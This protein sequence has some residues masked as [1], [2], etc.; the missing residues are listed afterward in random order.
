MGYAGGKKNY[1]SGKDV[2]SDN[3]VTLGE[4]GKNYPYG[5][6]KQN[7]KI[8]EHDFCGH[9]GRS[10]PTDRKESGGDSYGKD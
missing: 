2:P 7:P 6:K 9:S 10:G 5:A 8:E 4:N 3:S 1:Q